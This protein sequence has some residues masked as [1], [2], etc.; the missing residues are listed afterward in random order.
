[1]PR[2]VTRIFGHWRGENREPK[3]NCTM[4]MRCVCYADESTGGDLRSVAFLACRTQGDHTPQMIPIDNY[5]RVTP[6]R[7]A[8]DATTPRRWTR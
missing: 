4:S 7:Y 2:D 1:M 8:G 5:P 6:K 3:E